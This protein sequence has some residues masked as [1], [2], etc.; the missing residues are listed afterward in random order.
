MSSKGPESCKVSFCPKPFVT[1]DLPDDS[2]WDETTCDMAVCQHP[3]CWATIR[4]IERGHPRILDSQRKISLD[5]DDRLPMV[6]IVNISDSCFQAKRHPHRHL[7]GFTFTKPHFLLSQ[8]SKFDS[9]F[10]GRPRKKLPDKDLINWADRSFKLPVLNLNETPLPCPQDVRNMAVVW[11]PKKPEDHVGPAEKHIVPSK[12]ERKKRKTHTAKDKSSLVLSGRQNLGTQLRAPGIIVPPPSPV[13]FFEPLDSEFPLFWNQSDTLPRYLLSDLL[14]DEE[15]TSPSP[16][17]MMQLA[18]MKKRP[19]LE[20]SRPDS[21]ISEKMVLYAHSLTLQRPALRYPKHLKRLY[22]NLKE[23]NR[24]SGAARSPGNG[25][26][27]WPQER[28]QQRMLKTPTKKQFQEAK[29]NPKRDPGSHSTLQKHSGHRTLPGQE[30]DKQHQQQMEKNSPTLQQD[31]TERPQMDY[32]E[33]YLDSSCSEQSPELSRIDS[34]DED[35]GTEIEVVLEEQKRT[36]KDLSASSSSRLSWNPELK[37][38]RILQSTD[39][40]DEENQLF[41]AQKVESPEA[42]AEVMAGQPYS[43]AGCLDI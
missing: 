35:V 19:P 4:R 11:I 39:D 13:H 20:N 43:T 3:Q 26:Q 7:P 36:S 31:S 12:D 29:K 16:E 25:K 41:G 30:S 42:E 17:M 6:T 15:K 28:Q 9:K 14:S 18:R 34:T 27:Q 33:N 10:Q 23:G 1:M 21:A 38:L 40:E 32:A 8:G 37:L 22:Y 2:Q 24:F 5:V